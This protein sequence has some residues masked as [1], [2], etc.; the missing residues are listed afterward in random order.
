MRNKPKR[1]RVKAEA[2]PEIQQLAESAGCSP[3]AAQLL[4]NRGITTAD[5]AGRFLNPSL[6]DLPDPF[7]LP[8]AEAAAERIKQALASHEKI[9]VHGDYDGDGVTSAALWTRLLQCL[10][11][12]VITKVPHRRRDGYDMRSP[13][14]AEAREAG[15]NLIITTDCGI[16][17]CE[18]VEEARAV[19]IDVIV[20][21]HH[22]PKDEIPKAVAVVNPHRADSVYP[23]PYLAGVGVAYRMG[24]ALVRHL[25]QNPDS[26]RRAFIDLAAIGTVTDMMP[27]REDNRVIVKH[28]LTALRE[29]KKAGIRALISSAGLDPRRV[30]ERD[31]GFVIGPRL[32]SVGRI[33]DSELSLRLL[34]TRDPQEAQELAATLERVNSERR[35]EQDRVM[36]DVMAQLAAQDLDGAACLVITGADWPP[37]VIGLVAGRLVERFNRPTVVI[38]ADEETGR[39][40]GSARSI[41]PYNLFEGITAAGDH[42]LEFGG[43]SHAAGLSLDMT[44]LEGFR[45][46]LNRHALDNLT[47]E[48]FRPALEPEMEIDPS[49]VTL[50]LMR[51]LEQ[52]EPWGMENPEPL[53]V[54]R[55][56]NVEKVLRMGKESQH[57]KLVVQADGMPPTDACWWQNGELS[58]H[59]HP[60]ESVTLCYRP[61]LNHF[62]GQVKVQFIVQDLRPADYEE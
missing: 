33:D 58:E 23:F 24:E 15:V 45:D 31:I 48:D 52:F 19:G 4:W 51:E 18:E 47:E 26:Y 37:G 35:L 44:N 62:N 57:L 59:L 36:A 43:H 49:E 55:G 14:I 38:A 25:G 3:T 21:D 17:R 7:L 5:E 40:R 42:L 1:W 32:N 34:M 60:G 12:D 11:G 6:N 46:A 10:G 20:T 39:G 53:F 13:F 22:T 61:D 41:S 28:G 50:K 29:T 30:S 54:S 2:C 16:Q 56:L 27:L 9:A 8:D